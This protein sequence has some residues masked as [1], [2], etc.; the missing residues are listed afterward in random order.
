MMKTMFGGLDPVCP[1]PPLSPEASETAP[2][3]AQR[4]RVRRVTSFAGGIDAFPLALEWRDT[5]S[6]WRQLPAQIQPHPEHRAAR[7]QEHGGL[8][9]VRA[10]QVVRRQALLRRVIE[11]I[12]HIHE[13]FDAAEVSGGERPRHSEIENRLRR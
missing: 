1:N 13:E 12:E 4:S 5:D 2:N 6:G 8:R 9:E 10:E 7:V 11:R 3:A